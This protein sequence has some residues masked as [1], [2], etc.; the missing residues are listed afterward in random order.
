MKKLN[1][2]KLW[3]NHSFILNYSRKRLWNILM[4]AFLILGAYW[5]IIEFFSFLLEN[6]PT[7]KAGETYKDV[8]RAFVWGNLKYEFI[9]MLII[10]IIYNRQKLSYEI[11]INNSDLKIEFKFCDIFS[12]EGAKVIAVMDTFETEFRDNLVDRNTLHGKVI[13][14]YYTGRENILDNEIVQSLQRTNAS[15]IETNNTFIGKQNRYAIGTTVVIKPGTEYFYWTAAAAQTATGNVLVR[16]EYLIDA[17]ANLWQFIPTYGQPFETINIPIIG[18]GVD[19][20]PPEYTHQRIAREIANSFITSS[21]QQKFCKK[22][23][24]CL[25]PKDSQYFDIPKLLDYV[26]HLKEY[27]FI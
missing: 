27:N 11:K 16:P 7:S 24:I 9:L 26:N 4:T 18:K 14:N 2:F 20:L 12:Q 8:L 1:Q 5:T 17:L 25:Y 10:A 19:R 3:V 13:S 21:K 22:L 23:R 6:I 15:L